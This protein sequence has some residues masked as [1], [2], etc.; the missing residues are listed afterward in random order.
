MYGRP[1]ITKSRN[2][3]RN[4][5]VID[6]MFRKKQNEAARRGWVRHGEVGD[7]RRDLTNGKEASGNKKMQYQPVN[8]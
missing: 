1:G 7:G 3:A 2:S 6:G 8:N 4:A 5:K